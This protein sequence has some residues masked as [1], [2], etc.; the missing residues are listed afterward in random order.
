MATW[1]R[2][3]ILFSL[4]LF[5]LSILSIIQLNSGLNEQEVRV[6]LLYPFTSCDQLITDLPFAP[7]FLVAAETINNDSLR[8]SFNLS[9]DWND[10]RCSELVG[11]EAMSQ[12]WTRGVDAFIGPGNDSF[13]ATSARI[14]A[15][16]NLP[17]ISYVSE[18]CFCFFRVPKNITQID[19]LPDQKCQSMN[20]NKFEFSLEKNGKSAMS[21]A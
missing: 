2:N 3:R 7:A 16:W 21:S 14:A 10:T 15:S 20:L 11:I 13:C 12:Q 9:I 17:M 8:F 19:L 18:Y 4:C 5:H 6:V 1:Q